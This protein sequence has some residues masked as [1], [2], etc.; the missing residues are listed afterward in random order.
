MEEKMA[1]QH[2]LQ[3]SHIEHSQLFRILKIESKIYQDAI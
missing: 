1:N 3:F 2:I